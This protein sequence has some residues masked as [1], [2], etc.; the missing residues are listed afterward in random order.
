MSK[1]LGMI[2]QEKAVPSTK[3]KGRINTSF[4]QI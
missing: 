4:G 2:F 1:H 3:N